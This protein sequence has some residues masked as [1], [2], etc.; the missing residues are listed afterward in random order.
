EVSQQWP[1]GEEIVPRCLLQEDA[2]DSTASLAPQILDF[3]PKVGIA[4]ETFLVEIFG[5]R[6]PHILPQENNSVVECTLGG[7]GYRSPAV[8]LSDKRALCNITSPVATSSKLGLIFANVLQAYAKKKITFGRVAAPTL[9]VTTVLAEDTSEELLEWECKDTQVFCQPPPPEPALD[10]VPPQRSFDPQPVSTTSTTDDVDNLY[11]IWEVVSVVPDALPLNDSAY[12]ITF[13]VPPENGLACRLFPD[14]QQVFASKLTNYSI[15]CP[16]AI[17]APGSYALQIAEAPDFN[18]LTLPLMIEVFAQP[19]I[20]HLSPVQVYPGQ[21]WT[22]YLL[23]T[24]FPEQ[25]MAVASFRCKVGELLV[26]GEV[27]TSRVASCSL[28][29]EDVTQIGPGRVAVEVLIDGLHESRSEPR[30]FLEVMPEMVQVDTLSGDSM[31]P[32]PRGQP[33]VVTG[34]RLPVDAGCIFGEDIPSEGLKAAFSAASFHNESSISCTVPQEASLGVQRF[35]LAAAGQELLVPLGSVSPGQ[36][37]SKMSLILTDRAEHQ[38]IQEDSACAGATCG[39]SRRYL[40]EADFYRMT[41]LDGWPGGYSQL[42]PSL[43]PDLHS[44]I[45]FAPMS[46]FAEQVPL[47]FGGTGLLDYGRLFPQNF[48]CEV[49]T[50]RFAARLVR[51]ERWPFL[52]QVDL[53]SYKGLQALLLP[54]KWWGWG[55]VA[56]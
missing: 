20:L 27:S 43:L 44:S 13:S 26:P 53:S 38:D 10:T 39:I 37:T 7:D 42:L 17:G 32:L 2:V 4:G 41:G 29:S 9:Q 23:A 1:T 49:E 21:G 14:G 56:G 33:L 16:V 6:F 12:I 11:S 18:F 28:T 22:L 36:T 31:V 48:F 55:G 8:L 40:P 45:R 46:A 25:R 35:R 51:E 47:R 24:K 30:I 34:R 3:Y 15:S 54:V 19:S 52:C 50:L 5:R